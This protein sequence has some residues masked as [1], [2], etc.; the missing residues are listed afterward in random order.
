METI[1]N[2]IVLTTIAFLYSNIAL[3]HHYF[4]DQVKQ[5][6]SSVSKCQT[7]GSN[8]SNH[9]NNEDSKTGQAFNWSSVPR[10]YRKEELQRTGSSGTV[11][12]HCYN[13]IFKVK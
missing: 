4:P 5:S 7:S 10:L 6:N 9:A 2:P 8:I 12:R 13:V 11:F 1:I 3:L